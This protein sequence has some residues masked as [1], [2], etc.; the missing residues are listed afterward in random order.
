[1]R[2]EELWPPDSTFLPSGCWIWESTPKQESLPPARPPEG[3]ILRIHCHPL[4]ASG[5]DD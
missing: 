2:D 3:R 4:A 1:M 5:A